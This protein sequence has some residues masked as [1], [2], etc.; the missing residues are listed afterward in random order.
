MNEQ[1]FMIL[2]LLLALK[3]PKDV[4]SRQ[5][6][7][8]KLAQDGETIIYENVVEDCLNFMAT[9]AELRMVEMPI[10]KM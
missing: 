10:E 3:A 8:T 5:R 4:S 2:M 7:L 6:I 1:Q 9:I